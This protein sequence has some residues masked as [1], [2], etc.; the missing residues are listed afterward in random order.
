MA[1]SSV[2]Q[3]ITK[4]AEKKLLIHD[5]YGPLELTALGTG[6]ATRIRERHRL[7]QCFFNEVLGVDP[8]IAHRDACS[9]EHYISPATMEHLG[10]FLA[11]LTDS[12]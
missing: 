3:A 8:Q 6:E 10:E 12:L 7:L 5:R 11:S 1:K 2:N 9:I 4:L